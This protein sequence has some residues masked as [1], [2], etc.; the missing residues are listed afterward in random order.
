MP[1]L[2]EKEK[3][4]IIRFCTRQNVVHYKIQNI[5]AVS[6]Y[7]FLI[8]A[9]NYCYIILYYIMSLPVN[10]SANGRNRA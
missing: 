3:E 7:K 4:T 6:V 1:T 2:N 9:E 8:F 10:Y 5:I